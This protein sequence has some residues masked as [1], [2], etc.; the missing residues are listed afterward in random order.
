MD[1]EWEPPPSCSYLQ[2]QYRGMQA[3]ASQSAWNDIYHGGGQ[4]AMDLSNFPGLVPNVGSSAHMLYENLFQPYPLQQQPLQFQ[5]QPQPQLQPQPQ[6]HLQ[7]SRERSS[8]SEGSEKKPRGRPRKYAPRTEPPQQDGAIVPANVGA[9]VPANVGA[10]V[11]VN[12]GADVDS[13]GPATGSGQQPADPPFAKR[14]RGRPPGTGR[15]QQLG[16]QG[17]VVSHSAGTGLIPHMLVTSAGEACI[18]LV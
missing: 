5:P 3:P 15:R 2:Q 18:F 8:G 4:S 9:M 6:P 11:P 16:D 7:P 17:K 13:V 14:P 10:I 1:G 12:V